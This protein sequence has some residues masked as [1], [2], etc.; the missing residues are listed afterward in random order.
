VN[1]F[2][3]PCGGK[4]W[5]TLPGGLI[6]VE[7]EGIPTV[8]RDSKSFTL[9]ATTWGNWSSL[10]RSAA[11]RHSVPLPW[12]LAIA[13]ME[14][15]FLSSNKEAQAHAVSPVGAFGIMQIM[16]ATARGYGVTDPERLFDPGTNIETG[17]RLVHAL[18]KPDRGGLPGI[19]A[20]Y[21][22][23]RLCTQDPGR[24][25]WMLLADANYPRRVIEWNNTALESG[26]VLLF[27][28]QTF[29]IFGAVV[30]LTIASIYVGARR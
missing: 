28:P 11:S 30:G 27:G 12:L 26:M 9:M 7:G 24:N 8:P 4:R 16:P 13:T 18:D 29:A 10:L 19:S 2:V 17:A 25:E 14:T 20:L 21:N 1:D 15:G 5:R 22:S 6:E 23:G 3:N